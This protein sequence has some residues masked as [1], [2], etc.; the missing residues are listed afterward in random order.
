MKII[1]NNILTISGKKWLPLD[2]F[3]FSEWKSFSVVPINP[4]QTGGIPKFELWGVKHNMPNNQTYS[5][6]CEVIERQ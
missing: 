3:N 2:K 1:P 5:Y 4:R 6:I